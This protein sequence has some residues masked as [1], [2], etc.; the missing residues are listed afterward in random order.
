METLLKGKYD[1]EVCENLENMF[2]QFKEMW[3]EKNQLL[4]QVSIICLYW[5]QVQSENK[6]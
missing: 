2:Q 6:Q 5:K 4:P 1:F 3:K